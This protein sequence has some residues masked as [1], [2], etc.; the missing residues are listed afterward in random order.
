MK[1][2]WIWIANLIIAMGLVLVAAGLVCVPVYAT[3]VKGSPTE[4]DVRDNL[5]QLEKQKKETQNAINNLQKQKNETQSNVNSLQAEKN[6]LDNAVNKYSSQ[7]EDLSDDIDATQKALKEVSGEI[8]ELNNDLSEAQ[9]RENE[10]YELLKKRMKATYESGG[11]SGMVRL[12]ISSGSFSDIMTRSQYLNAVINYDQKKIAE[13]KT[14]QEIIESKKVVVEEKQAQLDA[15]QSKLDE[16][17]GVLADLTDAVRDELNET[18]GELATEKNKIAE[19]NKQ[20]ANLDSQMKALESKT[21]AAQ[22]AL[23]EKIAE[24]LLNKEDTGGYYPADEEELMWLAAT[25]QAEAGGESYTGKLAVGSV[26]MNRVKS[27]AFPNTIVGVITQNMQ[28]ASYRSGKVDLIRSN[29]PNSTC[30]QAA[31]EVL[32]GARVG[33]YLFFM[34]KYYAD[35]YGISE[36]TMIGNHAFFYRWITNKTPIA[37]DNNPDGGN[38]EPEAPQVE[39][40]A[41]A[42][43]NVEPEVIQEE[44]ENE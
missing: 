17:F 28:F 21:A 23:A 30:V 10:Q 13:F 36:Y 33:D 8:V 22:A 44:Q 40:P 20:L 6:S 9:Q 42:P 31:Q 19:Y 16:K 32:D 34:T 11:T 37:P 15:Y 27:S 18:N 24:R 35:Y 41:V 29:G 2:L 43:E 1:K 25:I 14:L 26:I 39:E 5:S 7:L 12:L 38:D 3:D 4:Q